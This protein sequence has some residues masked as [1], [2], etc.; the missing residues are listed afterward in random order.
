LAAIGA[1]AAR[2]R[3]AV[4]AAIAAALIVALAIATTHTW[5]HQLAAGVR[6]QLIKAMLLAD[7]LPL[8]CAALLIALRVPRATILILGLVLLQRTM[9]DG[10]I[11]PSIERR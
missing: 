2:E 6:P 8:A 11:Y 4:A 7:L 1:D 10:A 5:P 3:P 9:E